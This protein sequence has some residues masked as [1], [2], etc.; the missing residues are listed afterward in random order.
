MEEL[1][2]KICKMFNVGLNETAKR[3]FGKA[4]AYTYNDILSRVLSMPGRSSILEVFPE[5]SRPTIS[6]M[7]TKAFPG[8]TDGKQTWYTYLLGTIQ[9]KR[10]SNCLLILPQDMFTRDASRLRSDCKTCD[11]SANKA[12]RDNNPEAEKER[13]RVYYINHQEDAVART[14]KR[15]AIKLCAMP[16][17]ANLLAIKEIYNN[18]PEGHHVDHIVP[19]QGKNVCGL[20]VENNLQYLTV[21]E[22]LSKGNK[23]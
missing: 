12:R 22:N 16:T 9:M 23:Y 21:Q 19:L 14:A 8:K 17:W 15:R 18:C 11:N 3:K 13:A 7:L 2:I 1:K 5:F 4:P 10:C 6:N 20:H